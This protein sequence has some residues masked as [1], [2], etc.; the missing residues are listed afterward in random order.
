MAERDVHA[1]LARAVNDVAR[2][3]TSP[4]SACF[5]RAAA[6]GHISEYMHCAVAALL[7]GDI[8]AAV[9][10]ARRIGHSSG[11]DMLAGVASAIKILAMRPQP[12]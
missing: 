6:A 8:D 3:L 7:R 9:A 2:K 5:L 4:L 1:A 12:G 11:W 10:A